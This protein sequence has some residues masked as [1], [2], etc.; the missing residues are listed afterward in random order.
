MQ[1]SS[2]MKSKAFAACMILIML[3]GMM[4]LMASCRSETPEDGGNDTDAE[5]QYAGDEETASD[6]KQQDEKQYSVEKNGSYDSKEDVAEY[7]SIYKRLPKNYITKKEARKLGWHG[8]P[9]EKYAPGKAIGGDRFGNREKKLPEKTGRKY[10][11]CDI[12][13]L[14]RK[15]RGAR[16]I[17]YSSDGLIYYTKDHYKSYQKM[18]QSA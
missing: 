5:K 9:V 6:E 8:G 7:L 17:I 4:T 15:N 1:A 18:P 2:K 13:T 3:L 16:R 12:D 10:Y 14:G 11:E